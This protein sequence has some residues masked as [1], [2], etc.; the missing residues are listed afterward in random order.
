M[1]FILQWST[2]KLDPSFRVRFFY[3]MYGR[4]RKN[5]GSYQT[6]LHYYPGFLDNIP[7]RKLSRHSIVCDV[8]PDIP[9]EFK[10][11]IQI[12]TI[13]YD[14]D[15]GGLETGRN[16][17]RLKYEILSKRPINLFKREEGLD[18]TSEPIESGAGKNS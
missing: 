18:E 5:K 13:D 17:F 4:V 6:Y 12:D 11:V 16:K 14:L 7:P 9:K 3:S 1:A 2:A 8:L 10:D 15:L